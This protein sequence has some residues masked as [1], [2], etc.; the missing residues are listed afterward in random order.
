MSTASL[1]QRKIAK[2]FKILKMKNIFISIFFSFYHYPFTLTCFIKEGKMKLNSV[3]WPI[4]F[5]EQ[6]LDA[7][8]DVHFLLMD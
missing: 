3:S 5:K 1:I 8:R 2:N 4:E 6:D 7:E